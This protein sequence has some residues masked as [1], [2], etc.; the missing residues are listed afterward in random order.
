MHRK[1][2]KEETN[3]RQTKKIFNHLGHGKR[4]K[5]NFILFNLWLTIVKRRKD[6]NNFKL[7]RPY[8][9][10]NALPN[11]LKFI[12]QCATIQMDNKES[13]VRV[14]ITSINFSFHFI[15]FFFLLCIVCTIPERCHCAFF[16]FLHFGC[17]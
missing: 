12:I 14:K 6:W 11:H 13:D 1:G 16:L 3:Q 9:F 15:M 7:K 5:I 4:I 8:T 10:S 2:K 17:S